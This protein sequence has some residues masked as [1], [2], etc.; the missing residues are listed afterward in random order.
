MRMKN[1]LRKSWLINLFVLALFSVYS[2]NVS[3]D[4]CTET[5]SASG[6][7]SDPVTVTIDTF[8]CVGAGT[9]TA[10]TLDATIGSYCTSWYSY[11]IY[12]NGNLIASD[13]C[14]QTGYDLSS[15]LPITSVA[16][17]SVDEDVYS[18]LITLDLTL[19]I[20]YT[21]PPVICSDVFTASGYDSDPTTVTATSFPCTGGGTITAMTM[22][23][24]IGSYCTS[25]YSYNIYVNGNQ[26]AVDQCNQTGYD[27]TS[28]LP[29]TSVTL[30]SVDE[31]V[32]SDMI[33]LSMT[34]NITYIPP[35]CPAPTDLLTS[36]VIATSA[37][38]GWTEGG[39]AT[40]WDIE[41]GPAGFAPTGTPTYTGVSNP[42]TVTGLTA[43]TDY[44]WYVRADCGGVASTWAGPNTFTT[45]CAA[46]VAPFAETFDAGS[47]PL[48]W[49]QYANTG[50]PWA[51]GQLGAAGYAAQYADDHTGNGGYF[52]W[53]DFSSSDDFVVL[54]G[55]D[56]DVSLLY[57]PY[58]SFYLFSH[59]T[60]SSSLNYLYVEA[61]DGADW[62]TVATIY[63]DNGGWTEYSYDLSNY[64]YGSGMVRLRFHAESGGSSDDYYNDL[65]LDDIS[66]FDAGAPPACANLS[67]PVD[68]ALDVFI[69][70]DLTWNASASV[71]GY[72]LSVGTDNPPTNI[73]NAMD[74][75]DTL[76]YSLTG[77]SYNTTYY[78]QVSP[79]NA[80]GT[81]AGCDIYQF[82]T[83]GAPGCPTLIAPADSAAPVGVDGDLT[84]TGVYGA[85][86]Y[87]L[88]IGTDN[89][90]TNLYTNLDLGDV[91]IYSFLGLNYSS[92]YYWQIVPYNGAGSATGCDIYQFTTMDQPSGASCDYTVELYDSY[93]D[94][95]NG[96][97]LTISVGGVPVLQDITLASGN[98]PEI[99]TFS[100]GDGWA[101]ENSYYIYDAEGNLF[102]SDGLS[103]QPGAGGSAGFASCPSCDY[104]IDLFDSYGD[105]W[106]GGNLDVL[107]DGIV[108]L[109]DITLSTGNGP[110][111][112]TFN[113]YHGSEIITVYTP[114]GWSYENS[115]IIYDANGTA[116][117]SDGV[118]GTPADTGYVGYSNC[119]APVPGSLCSAALDYGF[120]NDPSITATLAADE[121][122][123][124]M[125]TLD[126]E[127][128]NVNFSLCGSTIDTK[129]ELWDDCS[130]LNYLEINDDFCG[131][132]SEI[133]M[134]YLTAGVY[135]AKVYASAGATGDYTLEITADAAVWGCTDPTAVNYYNLANVDDASCYYMGDSC[136]LAIDYGFIN[137]PAVNSAT[138]AAYD[139]EWYSFTLDGDYEMV[140]VSLC[141]GTNFD[142]KLDI[143]DAC[144]GTMIGYEDD[145]CGLQSQ[146]DY[147]FLS[148]GTYFAKV[149]GYGSNYGSFNLN[150]TGTLILYGCM[151]SNATNYDPTAT[152]DDGSCVYPAW[153]AGV[154]DI[155]SPTTGA[156]LYAPQD[157][158]VDIMNYGAS[159]I[160]NFDV[161]YSVDGGIAVVETYMDTIPAFGSAT[162]IF[163]TQ[164]DVSAGGLH[165]IDAYTMLL[166]DWDPT[167]DSYSITIDNFV[168]CFWSVELMDSYGDGWN[169]GWLEI[170]IDG[171]PL[172]IDLTLASGSSATFDVPV[173]EGELI[174]IEYNPGQFASENSYALYDAYGNQIF[175][176]GVSGTPS[177]APYST[178]ASCVMVVYGCTDPTALNYNSSATVDDGSCEYI[179]ES[180]MT[181][182]D[183]GY[184]N[185]PSM[186][187][188]LNADKSMWYMF[189]LTEEYLNVAVSLCGSNF[190]TML[191]V[192][193]MC[194]GTQLGW[195][196]DYC[197]DQSQ[198]DFT[199]LAAGTY[200]ARI[201]AGAGISGDYTI[202]VTGTAASQVGPQ[203][204]WAFELTGTNHIILVPQTATIDVNGAPA[205]PGDYLGV[206]FDN[207]GV[208]VCG[209]YVEYTGIT[210][211][212]AAWGDDN[213]T[214]IKDGFATG[215]GF[216]WKIWQASTGDVFDAVATYIPSP[217][218]P[219]EGFY[220][221]NGMSGITA[222]AGS[223]VDYQ[224]ISI[225]LGWSIISTYIVPVDATLETVFAG[226]VNNVEIV[227][228]DGGLVYWPSQFGLNTI[229]SLVLGEGYHIKMNTASLLEL[230]G[231]AAVPEV[232]PLSINLGWNTFAYLRN[233]AAS[234]VTMLAPNA[235]DI[236][237]VK[238]GAGDV[239]WPLYGVDMIGDM[240]PGEGYQGKFFTATTITYPANGA[241]TTS[242]SVFT[243]KAQNFSQVTNT[244]LNMTVGIPLTAWD[245]D[246]QYGD[247]VGIFSPSGLLIGAG[248]FANENMAI[249]VWGNDELTSLVDGIGS[250]QEF[251]LRYWN[252]IT[253]EVTTLEINWETGSNIYETNEIA[254]AGKLT[255]AATPLHY[256]L[257]QNVPN[258]FKQTTQ[259]SF[260]LP[261]DAF[262]TISVFNILGDKLQEIVSGD[263][264]AGTHSIEFNAS[265]LASGTYLYRI[266]SENYVA[267]KNMI[268]K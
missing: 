222:L 78:W 205:Q 212:L 156:F 227:K 2:T 162:Y 254:V 150:I 124:Y 220:S 13:Q 264:A 64:S 232:T 178:V 242:K 223:V 35:S 63:E 116:V 103:G 221:A 12:V 50:G 57:S 5:G 74:V 66:I 175:I 166:N 90:P 149:Y 235:S 102:Y 127:Y 153:N 257:E 226:I 58:L 194:N 197:G 68:S 217:G 71:T 41:F 104:T 211:S 259:I 203:L 169:G 21:P 165:T 39:S 6:Y 181:A 262:I 132:Q 24:T 134:A 240:I 38:L 167:N 213:Q 195:N 174:E 139:V 60:N 114:G 121:E 82:T 218:M 70:V 59:N 23:A 214:S 67:M 199:S 245:M 118:S 140:S 45:A 158:T 191:E 230:A 72:Y 241:Y 28:Y 239:Y 88:N 192:V 180:C 125:V 246:I 19:N 93:G 237:L 209:G 130:A 8:P 76:A 40:L 56:I 250:G 37:D 83:M 43:S 170:Y 260:E 80:N 7:D 251:A 168:G 108:V 97:L 109:D 112:F 234:I 32:Y 11:N 22:D 210:T 99:F 172:Y 36:S 202:E 69:D 177:S 249:T 98:G 119:L 30:E 190:N 113:M 123:W 129:L 106:N 100:A 159:D 94:G 184:I 48:S 92:T 148:A 128:A 224:Q 138:V 268:I 143:Y 228:N 86:G 75:G 17:Q 229:G 216:M 243:G 258:P 107:V 154:T 55:P 115:Y 85:Q 247:E 141:N 145:Y 27:L 188:T 225:P 16:I 46:F 14:N 26:I 126:D 151:D 33:T 4:T 193:D 42:Y 65:L 238:N 3:A 20:T 120:V 219:N 248:V 187:G 147:P 87:Y 261:V 186:M 189:T 137:D 79:Y 263:F 105:G 176:D 89:P 204:P 236:E 122:V 111:T 81:A 47:T 146:V 29:I 77:L 163:N 52:T 49:T 51:F 96:G 44:D 267:T 179:G 252:Q 183:Y 152:W 84:W 215:E 117:F 15:Y 185:D 61:Y 131:T 206:F 101:Y 133:E 9:I 200:Y 173:Y 198:V 110:A 164:A 155:T 233:S 34:L 201:Y 244:G 266:E 208:L 171:A 25:W 144:G 135:Y 10:I 182:I 53:V 265:G 73:Y 1:L 255:P 95:W 253:D 18:D 157:V 161:A 136:S 31:D 91:N 207:N 54:E 62:D 231:T 196:D 256:S 160:Y 142:T